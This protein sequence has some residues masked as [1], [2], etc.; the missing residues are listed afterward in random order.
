MRQGMHGITRVLRMQMIKWFYSKYKERLWDVLWFRIISTDQVNLAIDPYMIGL[1][2]QMSKSAIMKIIQMTLLIV[3][4]MKMTTIITLIMVMN[5]RCTITF[6][7]TIFCITH[8]MLHQFLPLKNGSQTLQVVQF[9][10]VIV[11]TENI[12]VL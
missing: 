8:T 5:K 11:V 3:V 2:Y 9:H 7:K 6:K 10:E 12:T 4:I 1:D